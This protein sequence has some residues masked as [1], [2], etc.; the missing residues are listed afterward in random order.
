MP[1]TKAKV[2]R[3]G[4]SL[5]FVVPR[6]IVKR[7]GLKAGDEVIFEIDR[8]GIEDAFGSMK[9]WIVDPQRLKREVRKGG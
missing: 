8:A 6:E 5:G 2:R 9:D 3:L 1:L 7:L 4:S